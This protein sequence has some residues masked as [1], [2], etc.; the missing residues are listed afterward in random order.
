MNAQHPIPVIMVADI[1]GSASLHQRLNAQE[2]DRAIDRCI[3]RMSRS[4]EGYQGKLLQTAGDEILAIFPSAESACQSAIDMHQRVADLPPISGHKLGIRIAL[5]DS[6]GAEAPSAGKLT[7]IM[8]MAALATTDQIL[9]SGPVVQ[10]LPASAVVQANPRPD[11]DNLFEQDAIVPV[12]QI[13][14]PAQNG[15]PAPQHSMFGPLSHKLAERLCLR[16]R[17]KAYLIDDSTPVLS[18]GRDPSC[19]MLIQ[20]R[21]VSRMHARIERR[22]DGYYLIDTSTNGSFLSMQ[23][24]QE[25]TLRKHEILLEGSGVVCFGSSLNDPA[26]D[27]VEFEHL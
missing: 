6:D 23:G 24:R 18:L 15:A 22:R 10:T 1:S 4:V 5:H 16:Y 27:R 14:W 17:G 19:A 26:A 11:I 7:S 3:K 25:I 2:A 12:F 20:N 8:R 9:C 21:K 13:H